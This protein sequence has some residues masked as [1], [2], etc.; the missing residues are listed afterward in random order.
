[1]HLTSEL[2]AFLVLAALFLG[3]TELWDVPSS[4]IWQRPVLAEL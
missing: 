1:M 4:H 3:V 2:V